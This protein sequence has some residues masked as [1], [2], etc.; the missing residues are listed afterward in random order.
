MSKYRLFWKLLVL[1]RAILDVGLKPTLLGRY[2]N[3][4]MAF[5]ATFTH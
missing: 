3:A 1:G 2:R 4:F 5:D